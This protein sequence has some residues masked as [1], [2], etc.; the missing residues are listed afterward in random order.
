MKVGETE[1]VS[2]GE[3]EFYC[4]NPNE[5]PAPSGDIGAAKAVAR[6]DHQGDREI[7]LVDG[8]RTTQITFND[9]DDLAPVY[10][11]ATRRLAWH[12]MVNDRLQI[13]LHD[14]RTGETKQVTSGN[15][16]SSNPHLFGGTLVWQSWIDN[17]WEIFVADRL[18]TDDPR[19]IQLTDNQTHDM[20]P[21][22]YDEYITWQA[23]TKDSWHVVVYDIEGEH[24]SY[25]EKNKEGK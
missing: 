22:V 8:E 4:F 18:D 13:I 6:A 21:Q 11:D 14:R 12:A 5:R 19:V 9:Y 2:I 25:V 24:Y 20:F 23:Q 16:N 17:N 7:F 15:Y 3:G 10:D 1:C